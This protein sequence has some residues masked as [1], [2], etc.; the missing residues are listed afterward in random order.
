M[1]VKRNSIPKN[2]S[3]V[4]EGKDKKVKVTERLKGIKSL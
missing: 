1:M 4:K 2:I 3:D